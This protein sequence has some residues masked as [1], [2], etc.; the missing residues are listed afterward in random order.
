VS[1]A[2]TDEAAFSDSFADLEVSDTDKNPRAPKSGA[3]QIGAVKIAPDPTS[4]HFGV[5]PQTVVMGNVSPAQTVIRM[6]TPIEEIESRIRRELEPL[7]QSAARHAAAQ[8]HERTCEW[9]ES[10]GLPKAA[11]VAQREAYNIL[12]KYGVIKD[13]TQSSS[14]CGGRSHA[15]HEHQP[16]SHDEVEELV[17]ACVAMLEVKGQSI[18]LTLSAMSTEVGGFLLPEDAPRVRDRANALLAPG[19]CRG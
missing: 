15:V 18:E 6:E 11:R 4:K 19:S 7:L 3:E 17:Q 14:A 16:L 8:E 12:R 9:L 5:S 10:K 2:S 1:R 13:T